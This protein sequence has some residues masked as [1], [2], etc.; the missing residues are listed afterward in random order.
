MIKLMTYFI[1]KFKLKHEWS[2]CRKL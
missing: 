1:S 2:R